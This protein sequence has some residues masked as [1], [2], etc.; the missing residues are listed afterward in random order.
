MPI[1]KKFVVLYMQFVLRG[2]SP[3]M[4]KISVGKV[5]YP[6]RYTVRNLINF[7]KL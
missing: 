1:S 7:N 4:L 3:K 5:E 2:I 6:F